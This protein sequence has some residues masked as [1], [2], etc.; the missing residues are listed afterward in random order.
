MSIPA[1]L[2]LA[3]YRF[4]LHFPVSIT[5]VTPGIVMDVSAMF[6]ARIHFR[7]FGAG[8][9]NTFICCDGGKAANIWQIVT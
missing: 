2:S 4:S 7:V 5:Y 9:E 6:V 1:A 8:L 3:R